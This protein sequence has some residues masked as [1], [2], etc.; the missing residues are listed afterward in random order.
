MGYV[1]ATPCFVPSNL[2]KIR[3]KQ[4][5]NILMGS[6]VSVSSLI[7][8]LGSGDRDAAA[9]VIQALYPELKR[10]AAARMRRERT[11]HTWQATALVNELYVE[12]VKSDQLRV[13]STDGRSEKA[14]FF[15]LASHIMS[16]LLVRHARRLYRRVVKISVDRCGDSL[17]A[18]QAGAESVQTVAQILSNLEALNPRLRTIVELRVFEGLSGDEIATRVGCSRRTVMRDWNFAKELIASQLAVKQRGTE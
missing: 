11:D 2:N 14:A 5:N 9:R 3:R 4:R 10:M 13:T 8:K 15:G 1:P 7:G 18:E 16:R 17:V 6:Q 12:L